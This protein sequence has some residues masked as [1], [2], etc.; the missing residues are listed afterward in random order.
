MDMRV[1]IL[2]AGKGERMGSLTKDNP[3]MLI[4]LGNGK[5]LLETQLDSIKKSGIKEVSIVTGYKSEKV[6]KKVAEYRKC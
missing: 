1:I 3:K 6:E 2:A 5:T 4:P